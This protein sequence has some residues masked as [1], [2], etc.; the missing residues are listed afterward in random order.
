MIG[1]DDNPIAWKC[2]GT[3]ISDHFVLTAA[4]CL[5]YVDLFFSVIKHLPRLAHTTVTF[6]F[7]FRGSIRYVRLG[8]YDISIPNETKHVHF[9][10]VAKYPHP[11]YRYPAQ[12]HDIALLKLDRKVEFDGAIR[13]AC[14]PEHVNTEQKAVATGWGDDV[15]GQRSN[16]L[17]KV[18]LE[19]YDQN[20]CSK[21]Y[22]PNAKL[23][24]GIQEKYQL[25][26]GSMTDVNNTCLG[27]SGG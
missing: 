1:Y 7:N 9:T 26:A 18:T 6:F 21:I 13:P 25:C 23:L 10:I 20:V 12:Y 27:D 11:E 8:E 24:R 3:L 5:M 16:V 2:G 4:H 14:L 15:T 22:Q 19:T 17:L